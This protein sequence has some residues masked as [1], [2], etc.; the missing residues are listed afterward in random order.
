MFVNLLVGRRRGIDLTSRSFSMR[1]PSR[2]S[3]RRIA[4]PSLPHAE[5]E[6]ED[7][8]KAL[9]NTVRLLKKVRSDCGLPDDHRNRLTCTGGTAPNHSGRVRLI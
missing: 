7:T 6:P 1:T 4:T 2:I 3:V 9:R 5:P 8:I